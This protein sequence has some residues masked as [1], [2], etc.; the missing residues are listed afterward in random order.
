MCRGTSRTDDSRFLQA[1]IHR[2]L[3]ARLPICD[4]ECGSYLTAGEGF[5][6]FDVS[7]PI[8]S[9][10]SRNASRIV[11]LLRELHSMSAKVFCFISSTIPYPTVSGYFPPTLRYRKQEIH[12]VFYRFRYLDWPKNLSL[13]A[14][15]D[16]FRGSLTNGA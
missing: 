15:A 7:S 6:V 8:S 16:L 11:F 12:T 2:F 5:A 1:S 9:M 13:T 10:I 14:L 3:V 4:S